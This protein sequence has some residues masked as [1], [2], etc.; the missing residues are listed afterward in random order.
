MV[1]KTVRIVLQLTPTLKVLTVSKNGISAAARLPVDSSY[2]VKDTC[3][4][5]RM[6]Q[7]KPSMVPALK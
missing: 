7:I 3:V 4:Y 6:L 2:T 1:D 5:S